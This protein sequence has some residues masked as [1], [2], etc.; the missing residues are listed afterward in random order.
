MN[1]T[2]P[3]FTQCLIAPQICQLNQS[4]T[5]KDWDTSLKKDDKCPQGKYGEKWIRS[6]DQIALLYLQR[7][8][9]DPFLF[10]L[11]LF[12]FLLLLFLAKV[13]GRQT[14]QVMMDK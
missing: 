4:T 10:M 5:L 8:E 7:K 13:L 14:E 6:W 12:F 9:N 11:W 2:F 3:N 1:N